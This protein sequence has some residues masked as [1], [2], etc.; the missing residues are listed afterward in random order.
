MTSGT[1]HL[2]QRYLQ[3]VGEEWHSGATQPHDGL[4][5]RLPHPVLIPPP[6]PAFFSRSWSIP[7]TYAPLYS[8]SVTARLTSPVTGQASS[9]APS[10]TRIKW[11]VASKPAL[12]A[13]LSIDYDGLSASLREIQRALQRVDGLEANDTGGDW[14]ECA[15]STE[16]ASAAIPLTLRTNASLRHGWFDGHPSCT[17]LHRSRA[18][19]STHRPG[20]F[21]TPSCP[22]GPGTPPP[23]DYTSSGQLDDAAVK[24]LIRAAVQTRAV[25]YMTGE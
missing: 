8:A 10:A 14:L 17:T 4:L 25:L 9:Y 15:F 2:A 23:V 12:L 19:G 6:G 3:Q 20:S 18:V 11:Q 24:A 13:V 16:E 5:L 7:Y 22:D 1:R 21:H